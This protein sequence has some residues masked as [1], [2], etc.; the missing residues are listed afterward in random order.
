MNKQQIMSSLIKRIEGAFD[1][2]YANTGKCGTET[3]TVKLTL[4]EIERN[5]FPEIKKYDNENYTWE[6]NGDELI[7]DYTEEV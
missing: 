3:L 1:R 4:T 6:V 5:I 7:I 2:E